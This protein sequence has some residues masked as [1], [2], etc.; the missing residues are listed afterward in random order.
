[1]IIGLLSILI[2]TAAGGFFC[3]QN[4]ATLVQLQVG[5]QVWTGHLFG[6]FILGVLCG[7]WFLLG[8]SIIRLRRRERREQRAHARHEAAAQPRMREP[9]PTLI[10]R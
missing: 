9:R 8:V 2:P 5:D 7:C 3:W 1:L 4:R 10:R 6:V